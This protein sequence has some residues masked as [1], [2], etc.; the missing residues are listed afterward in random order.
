[1]GARFSRSRQQKTLNTHTHTKTHPHKQT[2]H[3]RQKPPNNNKNQDRASADAFLKSP[4]AA[5]LATGLKPF[6][7]PGA[8]GVATT[9]QKHVLRFLR[10]TD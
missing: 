3:A 2:T 1:M 7:K 5:A 6:L 10:Y 9:F 4:A 8:A